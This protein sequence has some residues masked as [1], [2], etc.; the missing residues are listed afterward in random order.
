MVKS[1]CIWNS[2]F[3]LPINMY[4]FNLDL[5]THGSFAAA[6]S[7]VSSAYTVHSWFWKQITWGEIVKPIDSYISTTGHTAC[8]FCE[9]NTKS[10]VSAS[11]CFYFCVLKSCQ[12]FWLQIYQS[13]GVVT[14]YFVSFDFIISSSPWVLIRGPIGM[15]WELSRQFLLVC[16]FGTIVF[17]CHM[18]QA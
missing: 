2:L 15:F 13:E 8:M 3:W 5:R 1:L 12:L 11:R 10:P 7:V 16:L 14:I 4:L 18:F 17:C 9:E 6:V